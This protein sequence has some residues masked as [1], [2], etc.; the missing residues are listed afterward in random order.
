[1]DK[2]FVITGA[3]DGIGKI[4]AMELA[5]TGATCVLVSRDKNKGLRVMDEL[6]STTRNDRIHFYQADL[7]IMSETKGICQQIAKNVSGIDGLL[8]NA[9]GYFADHKITSEGLE[10][11]FALNHMSY[12]I[13]VTELLPLLKVADSARIVNVSSEA[14]QGH[15]MDWDNVHGESGYK[16]WTSYGRSKLMNILFTYELA[17]RLS[18]TS[19]TANCLHPGFVKTKFGDNNSGLIGMGL[20]IAKAVAAIGLMKGS[21]TSIYLMTSNEVN[22]VSGKYFYKCQEKKSSPASYQKDCQERL[23]SISESLTSTL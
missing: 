19:I 11:T 21:E 16:G 17:S 5:K 18:D 12:F 14:H 20:K 23:W 13:M 6:K 7:S 3:T 8:N 4:S 1:M 9:G 2:T 22:G 10:Y 15:T